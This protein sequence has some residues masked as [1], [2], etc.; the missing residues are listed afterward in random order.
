[1]SLAEFVVGQRVY[2]QY[3]PSG[4]EQ[5]WHGKIIEVTGEWGN[6]VY[7]IKFDGIATPQKYYND[8]ERTLIWSDEPPQ[9][10]AWEV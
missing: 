2:Y 7:K 6:I 4:G 9:Q 1:M 8:D 3:N 5:K 10:P